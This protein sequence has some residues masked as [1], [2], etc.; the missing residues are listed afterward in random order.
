MDVLGCRR[1]T[2]KAK[3]LRCLCLKLRLMC[4]CVCVWGGRQRLP[5]EEQRGR[6]AKW[7]IALLNGQISA[8]LC[9]FFPIKSFCWYWKRAGLS[10]ALLTLECNESWPFSVSKEPHVASLLTQFLQD[11]LLFAH[12]LTVRADIY[13]RYEAPLKAACFAG[14]RTRR[15]QMWESHM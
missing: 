10:E 9:D 14:D 15:E 4:V 8:C 13:P 3:A 5:T 12:S 6:D 2:A 11:L 7:V 1:L